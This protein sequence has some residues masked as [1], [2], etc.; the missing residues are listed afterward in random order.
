MSLND[1]NYSTVI[2]NFITLLMKIQILQISHCGLPERLATETVA[3]G[4]GVESA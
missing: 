3:E 2:L 1:Y 4:C